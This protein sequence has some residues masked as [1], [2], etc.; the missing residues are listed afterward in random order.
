[1]EELRGAVLAYRFPS[2]AEEQTGEQDGSLIELVEPFVCA[3]TEGDEVCNELPPIDDAQDEKT[4]GQNGA[5]T[6]DKK[7]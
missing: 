2:E 5:G 3:A 6:A 7:D 4:R 1:M